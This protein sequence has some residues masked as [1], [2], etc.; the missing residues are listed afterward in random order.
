MRKGQ[1]KA[2]SDE[3]IERLREHIAKGGSVARACII[4]RR[5]EQA[6]RT[7]AKAL[8]LHFPTIR[9]LRKKAFG[10]ERFVSGL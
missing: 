7:Q 3:D 9:E 5:S 4:F 6:C 10:T 1:H 8:G 2:W